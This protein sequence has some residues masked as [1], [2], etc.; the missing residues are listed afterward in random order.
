MVIGWC[1]CR[2]EMAIGDLEVNPEAIV[3]LSFLC[4]QCQ[5]VIHF[6]SEGHRWAWGE[7]CCC[8]SFVCNVNVLLISKVRVAGGP[9]EIVLL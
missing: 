6:T 9:G 5:H 3:L 8:H 1:T 7:L 4:F 2:W